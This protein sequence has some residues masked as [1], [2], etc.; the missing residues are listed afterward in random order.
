MSNI[1]V[2][3]WKLEQSYSESW[4][5]DHI[6]W[7]FLDIVPME[8][9]LLLRSFHPL[10]SHASSVLLTL[11]ATLLGPAMRPSNERWRQLDSSRD[12][13]R[14]FPSFNPARSCWNRDRISQDPVFSRSDWDWIRILNRILVISVLKIPSWEVRILFRIFANPV[15][16]QLYVEVLAGRSNGGGGWNFSLFLSQSAATASNFLIL[17]GG[18]LS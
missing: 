9:H 12:T 3:W 5:R 2:P 6:R 1:L 13:W 10:N 16:D 8:D 7:I 15:Q 4:L 11:K 18:G 17:G 14:D